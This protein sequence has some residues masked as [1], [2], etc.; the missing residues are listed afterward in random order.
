MGKRYSY[1]A[2]NRKWRQRYLDGRFQTMQTA[3]VDAGYF[4]KQRK[5][6]TLEQW[7]EMLVRSMGYN[8]ESY[9][10]KT[11]IRAHYKTYTFYFREH[12]YTDGDLKDINAVERLCSGYLKLLFPDL[13]TLN[14]EQFIKYCLHPAKQLRSII[15]PK[16]SIRDYEYK[17][18]LA[19]I[20]AR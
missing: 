17:N 12:I 5:Y 4:I 2:A 11:T 13:N 7:R 15:R 10:P 14:K 9:P 16:L 8:P 6:F 1:F 20:E 19:K 18:S 3:I